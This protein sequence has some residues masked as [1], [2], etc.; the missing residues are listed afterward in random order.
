MVTVN[1]KNGN[2]VSPLEVYLATS[3]EYENKE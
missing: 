2:Q 1:E 3:V